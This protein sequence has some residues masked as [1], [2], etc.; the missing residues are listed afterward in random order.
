MDNT[1]NMEKQ[2]SDAG[3]EAYCP[4]G[5][6]WYINGPEGMELAG[7][8]PEDE[9]E[10]YDIL[11]GTEIIRKTAF[12]NAE[13]LLTVRIPSS[14]T[15][16]EEGALSNGGGWIHWY[17]GIENIL[18]S[19][20]NRNYCF[21]GDFLC[22]SRK[23]ALSLMRYTG[24]ERH[25]TVPEDI[26]RIF[27]GAFYNRVIETVTLPAENLTIRFPYEHGYYLEELLACFGRNGL[28]YDFTQYDEFLQLPHYNKTRIQMLLDRLDNPVRLD[29]ETREKLE[30]HISGH[31]KET[32][33]AL[34]RENA[35]E[36]MENLADAGFITTENAEAVIEQ[37]NAAG[38]TEMLSFVMNFRH[39]HLKE[40]TLDEF[41]F[42]I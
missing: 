11:P 41:D 28:L 7:V 9:R 36:E 13:A 1:E 10:E 17:K 16:I 38:K 23:E 29:A 3:P 14:V 4:D 8:Q 26:R 32:T 37:L 18:L 34:I 35:L 31:M 21:L 39:G 40:T 22:E 42:T 12:E 27:S 30:E 33:E 20:E 19:P 2:L 25:V 24:K 6:G 5:Y 15:E